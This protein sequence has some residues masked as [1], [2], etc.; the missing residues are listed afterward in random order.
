MSI[1][2]PQY[3]PLCITA[4]MRTAVVADQW[5]PIDGLLFYQSVRNDL[6]P[7]EIDTP[8]EAHDPQP[9]GLPMRGSKLPIKYVH[10]KDWYY[11]S[12]WAQWGPY[13]D[14]SDYWSKRFNNDLTDMIDFGSKRGKVDIS[15]G[16]YKAYHMPIYYR[17]AL[18]IQWYCLGDKNGIE[19]LLSTLTHIGK[20]CAQ[21]WGHVAKWTVEPMQDDWS[22]WRDGKLMRG[23]PVYHLPKSSS[24]DD[25]TMG[26]Y[27]IR[28]S[29][30]D[31]RNQM[32]LVLP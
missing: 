12:S 30:W 17:S 13:A 31:R 25:Y 19:Y 2:N 7:R 18:W 6:G 29:Y 16:N 20:K 23:I 22:I 3:E 24:K 9:H 10:A 4:T 5:F 27:G 32:D 14:G 15:A 28:P 1:S 26:Y 8:G 21:G 11:C